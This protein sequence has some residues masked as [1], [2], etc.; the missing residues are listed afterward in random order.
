M[1][2]T[3]FSHYLSLV[4]LQMDVVSHEASSMH[5]L[6]GPAGFS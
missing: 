4:M 3:A 6:E 1:V 2:Y 5:L